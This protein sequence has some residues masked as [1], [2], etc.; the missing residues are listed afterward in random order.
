METNAKQTG[1]NMKNN[2][3]LE[4]ESWLKALSLTCDSYKDF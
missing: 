2:H 4:Y 1:I 3:I